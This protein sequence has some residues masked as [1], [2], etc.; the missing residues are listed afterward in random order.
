MNSVK[1][2]RRLAAGA[3]VFAASGAAV[4][5]PTVA[6]NAAPGD[7][8]LSIT[9][10]YGLVTTRMNGTTSAPCPNDHD[11]TGYNIVVAG[12]NVP[13]RTNEFVGTISGTTPDGF[14]NTQPF[15]A[16]FALS[17]GEFSNLIGV[18]VV[19]GKYDITL[20][21]V[22]DFSDVTRN[23][24]TSVFFTS[25]QAYQITAPSAT[26]DLSSEPH[27]EAQP[28]TGTGTATNTSVPLRLILL[29]SSILLAVG[30]VVVVWLRRPRKRKP[31]GSRY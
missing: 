4:A 27:T 29:G 15:K 11:T 22:T 14:S 17:F 3:V 13:G 31:T 25:P 21:C 9:P 8:T 28:L 1:F 2:I 7:G 12:P 20:R 23:F 24:T 6:A 5:I 16:P 10:P 18:P 26:P 19:P 30:L